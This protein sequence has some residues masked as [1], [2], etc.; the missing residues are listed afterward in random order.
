MKI[1]IDLDGVVADFMTPFTEK[2]KRHSIPI[3]STQYKGLHRCDE[4]Q[5]ARAGEFIDRFMADQL[6]YIKP[7]EGVAE[8]LPNIE[9]RFGTI[10][11]L[12]AR[13]EEFNDQTLIWIS[14]SFDLEDF[15]LI[16]K[17]SR[18]KVPFLLDNNYI[19]FV[20]D[21]LRTAN[22]A[23]YKGIIAYLM[24]RKWNSGR[25]LDKNLTVIESLSELL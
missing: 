4:E 19:M 13:R 6:K 5:A 11:F 2:C 7:Y 10:T 25:E 12:T 15:F 24:K 14:E 18:E 20:D 17:S 23:S 9:E 21:R 8:A 16:N 3:D 1:A 22:E